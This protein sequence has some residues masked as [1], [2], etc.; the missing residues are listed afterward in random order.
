M[1]YFSGNTLPTRTGIIARSGTP[2][3]DPEAEACTAET[4]SALSSW[5]TSSPHLL[6]PQREQAVPFPSSS[7]VHSLLR[8]SSAHWLFHFFSPL[9]KCVAR[10]GP[11]A[12]ISCPTRRLL[13][14]AKCH[15]PSLFGMV[16]TPE[17]DYHYRRSRPT[18]GGCRSQ[19]PSIRSSSEPWIS[20]SQ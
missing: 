7:P 11:T 10:N 8:R 3:W 15:H 2:K 18:P 19:C 9:A 4:V 14:H 17:S 6:E 20:P 13:P 5:I 12:T 1:R 16:N